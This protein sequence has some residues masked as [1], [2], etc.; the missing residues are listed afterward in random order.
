L[1][2]AV[3]PEKRARQDYSMARVII[4]ACRPYHWRKEFAEVISY[5]PDVRER[6]K[7]KFSYLW[8]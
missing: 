8:D 1:D 4:N 5:P 7:Q 2:P 6:V 3:P